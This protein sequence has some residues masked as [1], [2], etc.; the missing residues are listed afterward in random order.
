MAQ[1]PRVTAAPP[2]VET[3]VVAATAS[4]LAIGLAIAL[5]NGAQSNTPLLGGL[6]LW[7]QYLL[8]VAVP[9]VLAFLVGYAAPHT[10]RPDLV[11]APAPLAPVPPDGDEQPEPGR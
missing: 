3:K 2:V 4:S 8:L 10:P 7:L 11:P 9:P 1:T 5:L 6:P